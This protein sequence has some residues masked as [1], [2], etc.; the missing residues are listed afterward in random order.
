MRWGLHSSAFR[1]G[2]RRPVPLRWIGRKTVG[3]WGR[4]RRWPEEEEVRLRDARHTL[5][6]LSLTRGWCE[7]GRD[8]SGGKKS[9][10]GEG[11]AAAS[12]LH[13]RTRRGA[14]P[15]RCLPTSDVV[16]PLCGAWGG[17]GPSRATVLRDGPW[18]CRDIFMQDGTKGGGGTWQGRHHPRAIGRR[19]GRRGG[20][21]G[22]GGVP[23]F[24]LTGAMR[25]GRGGERDCGEGGHL[26]LRF[27]PFVPRLSHCTI[28][29]FRIV[30]V[31]VLLAGGS[32][33]RQSR[34]R[35]PGGV[36]RQRKRRG[37]GRRR[38]Q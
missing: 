15:R 16:V 2:M 21:F 1:R 26:M 11:A 31:A 19:R 23:R 12:L 13:T 24:G 30:V 9:R 20:P 14:G 38:C 8:W 3:K 28:L 25:C 32:F 6:L 4:R 29:P 33:E 5:L 17:G 27:S 18:S 35:V 22:S 34:H 10:K 36:R 7:P 37:W